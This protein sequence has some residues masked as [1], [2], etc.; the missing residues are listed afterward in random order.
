M[1][2]RFDHR[3]MLTAALALSTAAL[4]VVV[5]TLSTLLITAPQAV[6]PPSASGGN[7]G[8]VSGLVGSDGY[9]GS[10]SFIEHKSE[11]VAAQSSHFTQD[12]PTEHKSE[13]VAAKSGHFAP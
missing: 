12:S 3:P 9:H 10:D 11:V 1:I 4:V 6:S 2:A 7:P 13:V 5:I 8:A